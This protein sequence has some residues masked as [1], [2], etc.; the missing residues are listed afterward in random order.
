[1]EAFSLPLYLAPLAGVTDSVFRRIARRCGADL[2]FSEM[3]SSRALT[4]RDAKTR[5]LLFFTPQERPIYIQIFGNDPAVMA[6]AARMCLEGEPE[7]ID[8][9]MGCPMPKVTGGGDGGAL[10]KNIDLAG[11]I[12]E[13]VARAVPV[14][15]RV[16]FRS[17]WDEE[18]LCAVEFGKRMEQCGARGLT[19]HP[20]T[21]RQQYAG[22]ADWCQVKALCEAV[23]IPVALSGDVVSPESARLAAETGA[24]ALMIGRAALGDPWIFRRIRGKEE[25]LT[26]DRR[27]CAAL[28]H[29][30]LLCEQDG[31]R[32]GMCE[33][34]KFSGWYLKGFPEAAALR[35]ACTRVSTYQA[36]ENLLLPR[37]GRVYCEEEIF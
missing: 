31:E 33:S 12:V 5:R 25:E 36:L 27:L 8:I 19:L 37:V 1:M 15:V 7:G 2:V 14:P 20:R 21:V 11:R 28:Y 6:E 32:L 17:G 9:N 29:A 34:R 4:Y 13:A 23:K 26:T 10:M 16:K 3:V 24:S 35:G 22:K 18:H 30:R